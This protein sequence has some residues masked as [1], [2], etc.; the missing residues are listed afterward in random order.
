VQYPPH[1]RHTQQYEEDSLHL[2]DLGHIILRE[3]RLWRGRKGEKE[4]IRIKD[5]G[6]IADTDYG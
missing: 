4:I 5:T 1:L 2:P 3:T 6:G